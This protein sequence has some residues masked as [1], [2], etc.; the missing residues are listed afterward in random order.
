MKLN[1]E[2]KTGAWVDNGII[3]PEQA[4]KILEFERAEGKSRW[5]RIGLYGFLILGAIAFRTDAGRL[6]KFLLSVLLA[7]ALLAFMPGAILP[8][9]PLHDFKVLSQ[10][11]GAGVSIT[12][13][14]L[15]ALYFIVRR[16]ALLF[17]SMTVLIAL[18][19]LIIYF[20]VFEDLA[21]TGAGLVAFGLVLMG[22]AAA[23]YRYR[24]KLEGWARR[25]AA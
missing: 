15:L 25:L 8:R 17:H 22:I 12:G 19:F 14:L 20:Q 13:G 16:N 4:Q 23:W 9:S 11:V 3:R 2:K 18:R 5:T 10:L 7:L 24:V 1:L 6:E 21:Y